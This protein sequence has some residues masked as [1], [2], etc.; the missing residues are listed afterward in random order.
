[1]NFA[2]DKHSLGFRIN[3]GLVKAEGK[4]RKEQIFNSWMLGI[5][6]FWGGDL[7]SIPCLHLYLNTKKCATSC[8][9]RWRPGRTLAVWLPWIIQWLCFFIAFSLKVLQSHPVYTPDNRLSLQCR[10][11]K[12]F[13]TWRRWRFST[14]WTVIVVR[15]DKR[16]L[17]KRAQ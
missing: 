17:Y 7:F 10:T 9:Q 6:H 16:V 14:L 15:C 4:G 11:M 12:R 13:G 5:A 3:L 8:P 1:M 2:C